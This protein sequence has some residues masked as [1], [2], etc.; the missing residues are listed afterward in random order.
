MSTACDG[1]TAPPGAGEGPASSGGTLPLRPWSGHAQPHASLLTARLGPC[2]WCPPASRPQAGAGACGR[3]WEELTVPRLPP[4]PADP[5]VLAQARPLQRAVAAA[6]QLRALGGCL[7]LHPHLRHVLRLPVVSA[8]APGPAGS[9]V[10]RGGRCWAW[11]S[12]AQAPRPVLFRGD[13]CP[14]LRGGCVF[15]RLVHEEAACPHAASAAGDSTGCQVPEESWRWG[16]GAAAH[17]IRSSQ[18]FARS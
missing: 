18:H 6:G 10:C 2:S 8:S 5:A 9:C 12:S 1:T 7:P 17:L 3:R 13:P 4:A 15:M 16:R 14:S 11:A